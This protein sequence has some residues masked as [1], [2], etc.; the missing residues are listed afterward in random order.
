MAMIHESMVK[1]MRDVGGITK[2]KRNTSQGFNFRGI[3]DVYNYLHGLLAK[4][5]IFTTSDILSERH[6][7]RIT[8]KGAL[9]LYRIYNIR[10]TF[11]AEDGTSVSSGVIG[12]GMDTGDKASNKAMAIADK[13]CLIQAFKIPTENMIDPDSVSETVA[14]MPLATIIDS[15]IKS[16]TLQELTVMASKGEVLSSDAQQIIKKKYNE[17]KPKFT[18]N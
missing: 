5:G 1:V 16:T 17:L 13:Y 12:E 6:E 7:E 18:T 8:K 2:S 15:M 3:D 11:Y 14:P 9:L 10:Y 4:H